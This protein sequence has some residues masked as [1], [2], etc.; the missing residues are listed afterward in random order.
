MSK[1]EVDKIC[2]GL[3]DSHR[4]HI[5]GIW[6]SDTTINLLLVDVSKAT[7]EEIDRSV[8]SLV[9]GTS[10]K[11]EISE[12]TDYFR[13]VMEGDIG[14]YKGI[15]DA[16][17]LYDPSHF[18]QPI[19]KMVRSGM[20]YGTKEALMRKFHSINQHFR[21]ITREKLRVLDNIYMSV[22][23]ASQATLLAAGHPIPVPKQVPPQIKRHFVDKGLLEK[24]YLN[25][26]NDIVG[27]FKSVEH[28]EKPIPS[29]AELDRLQDMAVQYRERL[30]ELISGL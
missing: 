1:E 7:R 30:K 24:K 23:E 4:K 20:I 2:A 25:Q 3:L 5:K 14:T 28:R 22:I 8:S 16:S 27:V 12:L 11:F 9:K 26:C 13:N 21:Q 17:L 6:L 18:V 29:G 10:L 19:K 15:R